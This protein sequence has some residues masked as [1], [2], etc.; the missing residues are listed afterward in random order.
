MK[1]S[2]RLLGVVEVNNDAALAHV[3]C[4]AQQ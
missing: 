2:S 3:M 1:A 4:L